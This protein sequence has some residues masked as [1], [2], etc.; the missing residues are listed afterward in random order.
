MVLDPQSNHRFLP[1]GAG[2]SDHD[3]TA[4]STVTDSCPVLSA[5]VG[6]RP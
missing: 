1:F 5:G 3:P 2:C 4:A 6:G